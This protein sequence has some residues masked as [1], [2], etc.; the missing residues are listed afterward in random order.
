MNELMLILYFLGMV[1]VPILRIRSDYRDRR[2]FLLLYLLA[3]V[4]LAI[5]SPYALMSVLAVLYIP[6]LI[7]SMIGDITRGAWF[8]VLYL[9]INVLV[10]GLVTNLELY[11][12]TSTLFIFILLTIF[13]FVVKDKKRQGR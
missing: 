12:Q 11:A 7:A 1:L 3:V 2:I 8:K 9:F 6:I 4:I 13:L 5:I 10:L